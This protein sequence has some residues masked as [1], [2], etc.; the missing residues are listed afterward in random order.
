MDEF[1]S[2]GAMPCASFSGR[3]FDKIICAESSNTSMMTTGNRELAAFSARRKIA[4]TVPTRFTEHIY[5]FL[6]REYSAPRRHV[7][8]VVPRNW[9]APWR[10]TTCRLCRR[11]RHAFHSPYWML[12]CLSAFIA[13][14]PLFLSSTANSFTSPSFPGPAVSGKALQLLLP[15]QSSLR[16]KSQEALNASPQRTLRAQSKA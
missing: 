2:F 4:V 16:P 14:K 10:T 13:R 8:K 15:N 5:D 7:R 3:T 11:V 1:F 6:S 12:R 9:L